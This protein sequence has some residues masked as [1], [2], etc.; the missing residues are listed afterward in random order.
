MVYK[1][2][3]KVTMACKV[4]LDGQWKDGW[5]V[6]GLMR[7]G[8]ILVLV[9]GLAHPVGP[10]CA[11]VPKDG[12]YRSVTIEEVLEHTPDHQVVHETPQPTWVVASGT[13]TT[14]TTALPPGQPLPPWSPV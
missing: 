12:K 13:I 3:G 10:E 4:W 6:K 9:A 2:R 14:T 5:I 8:C 1:T 11:L 7:G